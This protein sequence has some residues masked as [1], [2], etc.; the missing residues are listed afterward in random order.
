MKRL[1]L[2]MLTLIFSICAFAQERNSGLYTPGNSTDVRVMNVEPVCWVNEANELNAFIQGE[3]R[4]EVLTMIGEPGAE[5]PVLPK[6]VRV[7]SNSSAFMLHGEDG[8]CY[9]FGIKDSEKSEQMYNFIKYGATGEIKTYHG[10]GIASH[11]WLEPKGPELKELMA[12]KS[13]YDV[14]GE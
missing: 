11:K 13:I 12:A 3:D 2:S 14:L 7:S 9:F 4:A 8:T 1:V 10:I 6:I 5:M